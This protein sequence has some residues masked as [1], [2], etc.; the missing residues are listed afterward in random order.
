LRTLYILRHG[1]AVSESEA[2]TDHARELTERGSHAASRVGEYLKEQGKLPT[3][4][5]ASTAAR[6]RQTAELC[7][8]ALEQKATLRLLNELYLAPPERY[9]EALATHAKTH[10]V[11]LVVGHN[12]GLESLVLLLTERSEHLATAAL[13]EVELPGADWSELSSS[14]GRGV[15]RFIQAWQP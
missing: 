9:L 7:L 10:A 3:L 1:K 6:A 4:V 11:V 15:G 12:P 14:A 2:A 13:V 8:T 5:L